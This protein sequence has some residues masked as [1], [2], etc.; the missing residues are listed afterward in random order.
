V[1]VCRCPGSRALSFSGI[2]LWF[3]NV[4]WQAYHGQINRDVRSNKINKK[5]IVIFITL[6]CS[7]YLF[8][9]DCAFDLGEIKARI[10]KGIYLNDQFKKSTN[11]SDLNKY[12]LQ[13][14]IVEKYHED[15]LSPA[16]QTLPHCVILEAYS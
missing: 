1:G 3:A 8:G 4:S 14:K 5:L 6:I 2:Y 12:K 11:N 7:N 10:E 16:I 15:T 13:L 9:N